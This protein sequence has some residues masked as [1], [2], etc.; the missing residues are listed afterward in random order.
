MFAGTEREGIY[1]S[2]QANSPYEQINTG[3]KNTF[4]TAMTFSL[5]SVLYVGTNSYKFLTT[6]NFGYTWN[7]ISTRLLHY[8]V[9]LQKY[10]H[11]LHILMEILLPVLFME[12]YSEQQIMETTGL[13]NYPD[14]LLFIY[15]R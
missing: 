13:M 1:R 6:S 15:S 12:E 10:Y 4:I 11:F 14:P 8:P 5:D 9:G 2:Q 3:L 7:D